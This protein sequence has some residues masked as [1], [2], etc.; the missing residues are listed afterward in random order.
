MGVGFVVGGSAAQVFVAQLVGREHLLDA[1]SK[2]AA[3]DS[4]ARLVGPGVAGMLVQALTAPVAVP[5]NAVSFV[6]SWWN[7]CYLKKRDPYPAPSSR[8]PLREMMDSIRMVRNHKVLWALAWGTALWQILFNGYLALQ[9]L[10]ATHQLDM[11]ELPPK[12][13]LP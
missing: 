1:Q 5:V 4:M 11:S 3:T 7:L 10:F 9:I 12:F 6:S 13:S 8:H 2:F